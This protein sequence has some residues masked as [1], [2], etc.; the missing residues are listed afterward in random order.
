MNVK[1]QLLWVNRDGTL[2]DY[3]GNG[4]SGDESELA[5]ASEMSSVG[6]NKISPR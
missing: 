5:E 4:D 1:T 6:K 2:L 3:H